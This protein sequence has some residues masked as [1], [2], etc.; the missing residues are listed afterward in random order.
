MTPTGRRRPCRSTS[1]PI[2]GTATFRVDRIGRWTFTVEAWTDRYRRRGALVFKKKLDA[3][4]DVTNELLE[5]GAAGARGVT[6][7]TAPVH[8]AHRCS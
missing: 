8:R 3:G 1:T 2:A 6:Q 5:G 4:Q 7:R